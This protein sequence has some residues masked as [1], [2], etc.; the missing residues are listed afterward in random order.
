GVRKLHGPV[1]IRQELRRK[2]FDGELI[3]A[4]FSAQET[5]W[6]EQACEAK[7]KKFGESLPADYKEK[8]KQMRYLMYRGFTSDQIYE[9]Y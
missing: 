6:F 9:L 4:V 7:M 2:G 5:D 8:Q 1:R 3:D